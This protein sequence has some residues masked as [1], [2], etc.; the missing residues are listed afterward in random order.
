MKTD[1]CTDP[2]K[3]VFLQ[4]VAIALYELKQQLQHNYERAYPGLRE[5]IQR[6]VD[7]EEA[8]AWELSLFPHLLLPDMVEG[9][10]AQL[11]S[12]P[13]KTKRSDAIVTPKL[14]QPIFAWC[15]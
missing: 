1:L 11:N 7:E 4:T 13:A 14:Q 10:V 3:T 12:H 6:V 15:T 9:R 5:V 2:N 8:K